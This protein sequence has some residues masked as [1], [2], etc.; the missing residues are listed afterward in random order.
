[1]KKIGKTTRGPSPVAEKFKS[2]S[3]LQKILL[4]GALFAVAVGAFTWFFYLPKLKKI[5]ELREQLAK[6]EKQ[7]ETVKQKASELKRY[8]AEMEKAEA[9][10][11]LARRKLPETEEIPALLASISQSGQDTG[12]EFVLF[13]PKP[14]VRKDF[15]AEIPVAVKVVGNYHNKALF[16]DR[17][18]KLSRIVNIVDIQ[19]APQKSGSALDTACTAVTYK[20]IEEPEKKEEDNPKSKRKGR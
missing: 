7:L 12:L 15:Y 6:L 8:Q 9:D 14:E 18:S 19:M 10:F 17:V 2:L 1:M 20:Y 11:R 3:R 4:C 13:Q 16:F 5:G